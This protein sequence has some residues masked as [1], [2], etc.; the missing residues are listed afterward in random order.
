MAH[1][2][3]RH[4]TPTGTYWE[5]DELTLDDFE[6]TTV[7]PDEYTWKDGKR[8]AVTGTI[9]VTLGPELR[10]DLQEIL[11]AQD[12]STVARRNNAPFRNTGFR[13]SQFDKDAAWVASKYRAF[14][15]VDMEVKL[16]ANLKKETRTQRI[17]AARQTVAER[18]DPESEFYQNSLR[19]LVHDTNASVQRFAEEKNKEWRRTTRQA[20]SGS[21]KW[22]EFADQHADTEQE[23]REIARTEGEIEYL[24][25]RLEQ[26]YE[27]LR[28][29]RSEAFIDW[30]DSV[31]W[32]WNGALMPDAFISEIEQARQN[33]E[34][35]K[36]LPKHKRG[37][38]VE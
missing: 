31:Q 12:G 32:H 18:L 19:E 11:D 33:G 36:K 38:F 30:F 37:I 34:L 27:A 9:T 17:A 23:K 35:L 5:I 7:G 10:E 1:K 25:K 20:A 16:P 13:F 2:I 21:A 22:R 6:V 3:H 24:K 29:K 26:Q 4:E 28:Q 14:I 15:P 8:F